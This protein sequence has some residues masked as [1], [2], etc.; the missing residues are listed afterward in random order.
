VCL[1]AG[2]SSGGGKSE[3]SPPS[4]PSPQPPATPTTP[5]PIATPDLPTRGTNAIPIQTASAAGLNFVSRQNETPDGTAVSLLQTA[6][7]AKS[8]SFKAATDTDNGGATL[9]FGN[10][11]QS[12]LR[13]SI[14]AFGISDK[15]VTNDAPSS[16][17]GIPQTIE[18]IAA[19][20][21]T[22]TTALVAWTWPY[23]ITG[24]WLVTDGSKGTLAEFI[25]GYRT[26]SAGMPTSGTATYSGVGN[27]QGYA[28]QVNNASVFNRT[29]LVQGDGSMTVD[30][31]HG[32]VDGKLTKMSSFSSD[33][34][35][36]GWNDVA[37]TASLNAASPSFTGTTK[38]TSSANE[39]AAF[40]KDY[41]SGKVSGEF[42]GPAA[43]NVGAI[44]SLSDAYM[45][46]VGTVGAANQAYSIA[47][48]SMPDYGINPA[49]AVSAAL[50][51]NPTFNA[52]GGTPYASGSFPALHTALKAS[53]SGIASA[54]SSDSVAFTDVGTT[55]FCDGRPGGVCGGTQFKL[56]LPSINMSIS[57]S[58]ATDLAKTTTTTIAAASDGKLSLT[59]GALSYMTFGNWSL[60]LTN[61][62]ETSD[63]GGYIAGYTT[64]ANAMPAT[65]TAHY[66]GYSDAVRGTVFITDGG[67]TINQP[68][69]GGAQFDVDF[70][71]G[72]VAG[73]FD[74]MSTIR[75]DGGLNS[76]FNSIA[77][78]ANIATGTS[79]FSGTTAA[80]TAPTGNIFVLKGNATGQI[81]GGFYGPNANELGAVWTLRNPDGSGAAA[82]TVGATKH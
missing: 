57:G 74:N 4:S 26:P 68:V 24:E 55:G 65:G 62:G 56:N 37:F 12:G 69:T 51:N 19:K 50:V 18:G 2:C 14:P 1:A 77:V 36:T 11:S 6:V 16:S 73:A 9:T 17:Y 39:N 34:M 38:V 15:A 31:A 13:L 61:L 79:T 40:M 71:K 46:A 20:I 45:V 33:G 81:S 75:D 5:N 48:L 58:L 43:E 82:G 21:T 67:S 52:A 10:A 54:S 78:N 25:T 72:T 8:T 3:I 29:Y 76:G 49:P 44:W 35:N 23:L 22:N 59:T 66:A 32:T 42:Y 63:A 53:P 70:A 64:P 7:E 60:K 47:A 27:V 80:T 30:F 41:A 28:F